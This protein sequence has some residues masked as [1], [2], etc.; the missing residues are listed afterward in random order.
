[1]AITPHEAALA[2]IH[3][4]QDGSPVLHAFRC[5]SCGRLHHAEHAGDNEVPH[6]CTVCGSGVTWNAPAVKIAQ[7][8]A[9]P[10]LTDAQRKQMA[11]DLER[12]LKNQEKG[13]DPS[14]WEVL[15]DATDE[16]LAELG[17]NRAHVVRHVP[18]SPSQPNPNPQNL[19]LHTT[20]P[21]TIKDAAK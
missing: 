12:A 21:P 11:S 17:I 19:S 9:N 5:K 8:I 4:R 3:I 2:G 15:H 14:N 20:E 18:T 6:S 16:R 13:Y 10:D 7:S 1:M